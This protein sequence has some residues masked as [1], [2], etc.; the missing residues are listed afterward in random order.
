[1]TA[2][3]PAIAV[4]MGDPLGIGPEVTIKALASLRQKDGPQ[5]RIYGESHALHAAADRASIEPF[6]WRVRHD[7]P[8]LD[9][10]SVHD[11]LLLDYPEFEDAAR[12]APGPSRLAGEASFR[13]VDDAIADARRPEHDPRRVAGIVTAPI[14][15][16]A[17]ALAG[18][19]QFPGHTELLAARF[20]ARRVRMMF[21][22]PRLRVMLVT[23][24]IPLMTLGDVLSIGRVSDTIDLAH[25]ACR[26]LGVERPRV[27]VCGLN[28]HAGEAG[29]LGHEDSKIIEPAIRMAVERGVAATG[30]HPADTI[31]NAALKGHH[32]IVVAMYHDQGLIPVKLLA[33]DSAVNVTIGLPAVRTSP[34]HGTAFDIAGKSLADPGSMRAAIAHAQLLLRSA[35]SA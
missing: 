26:Q 11:V 13:F 12:P 16:E 33:F 29:L 35:P 20:A 18:H 17:W 30:P 19:K 21:V 5:I 15:K 27:A 25:E 14:S 9:T 32:D 23:A 3:R 2:L 6:W 22:A 4:S 7:F 28:P 1:M 31:F 24:H 10:T 8:H 34:D